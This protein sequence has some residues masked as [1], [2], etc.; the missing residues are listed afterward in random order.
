MIQR[1]MIKKLL[2]LSIIIVVVVAVV[3][4]FTVAAAVVGTTCS[5][6]VTVINLITR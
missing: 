3:F 5:K 1:N 6:S 2:E 4:V